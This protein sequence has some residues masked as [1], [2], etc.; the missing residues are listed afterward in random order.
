VFLKLYILSF[1]GGATERAVVV[2][3]VILIARELTGFTEGS[4]MEE[5]AVAIEAIFSEIFVVFYLVMLA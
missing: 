1:P 3:A 4:L 5:V 2:A